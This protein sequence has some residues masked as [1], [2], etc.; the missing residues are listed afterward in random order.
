MSKPLKVIQLILIYFGVSLLLGM[1]F[2]IS[3]QVL[4][5]YVLQTSFPWAEEFARMF[6][7]WLVCIMLPVIESYDDQL[8]V[9]FI[10]DK[11]PMG[12]R[13]VLF[14]VFNV[15]YIAIL[16]GFT[17]GAFHAMIGSWSLTFAVTPWL[18]TGVEY[19]SLLIG[20]PCAILFVVYRMVHVNEFLAALEGE[21]NVDVTNE[22]GN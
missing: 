8:K 12:L 9:A 6:Y 7:I 21:Y 4:F 22:E 18:K 15:I 5:R 13:K 16:I 20:A 3:A 14:Y 1:L 11:L 19:I 2:C 17:Y 10:F